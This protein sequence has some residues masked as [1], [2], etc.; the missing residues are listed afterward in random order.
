MQCL[1]KMFL[2]PTPSRNSRDN[3]KHGACHQYKLRLCKSLNNSNNMLEEAAV[4]EMIFG[5]CICVFVWESKKKWGF[6]RS[7]ILN[8]SF[9]A[10]SRQELVCIFI[11]ELIKLQAWFWERAKKIREEIWTSFSALSM[12][13]Y[14]PHVCLEWQ[15]SWKQIW[16]RFPK[17]K[18]HRTTPFAQ[19]QGSVTGHLCP[20][21]LYGCCRWASADTGLSEWTSSCKRSKTRQ[22]PKCPGYHLCLLPIRNNYTI[23][24][25]SQY[26]N[27]DVQWT[28]ISWASNVTFSQWSKASRPSRKVMQ[29]PT[30]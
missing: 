7:L 19:F 27:K 9:G 4:T 28:F 1:Q 5:V 22:S 18:T 11:N 20:G 13:H 23:D 14:Y 26:W 29:S 8:N 2:Q 30:I 16:A 12:L 6:Q 25:H 24:K 17:L 21:G 15:V 10:I 3:I